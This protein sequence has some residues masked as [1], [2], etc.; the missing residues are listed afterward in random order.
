[1]KELNEFEQKGWI[2]FEYDQRIVR[3]AKVANSKIIAKQKNKEIFE[4]GLTCQGT[5]FV[6]VDALDNN[7]DGTL[8]E[9]PL[10]GPFENLM[11]RSTVHGLHPA[12]VSIIFEGYPKPRDQES[13]SSFNFR[14]K[15]DAAHIDGL[16]ADFPGGPRK[17]KEPHA[18]VLGIPLNQVPK[19]A[20]PVVVWE[21]SHHLISEA[22]ERFFLNRTPHEWRDIDIREVYFETR[23]SIFKKCI[24]R[25]LHANVGESYMV[26]R[27]CLHGISPWNSK[28]KNFYAGRRIAYFRPE[29]KDIANWPKL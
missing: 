5:W 4:N 22:F 16:I 7:P 8:D 14:H 26:H 13:E 20:S 6:G 10:Q 24:R 27:L 28:I 15:R 23:K 3:W 19:G 11:K 17:L 1:M 29:L 25:I 12:Q 2:K 9:V 18:Y 21:G